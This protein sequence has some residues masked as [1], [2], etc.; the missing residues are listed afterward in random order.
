MIRIKLEDDGRGI[1]PELIK[2]KL[3]EKEL[4]KVSEL[5]NY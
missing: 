4:K 3:V 2:R 5:A 1:N